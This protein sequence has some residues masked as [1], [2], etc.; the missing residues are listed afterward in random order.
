VRRDLVLICAAA[1]LRSLG[2]G[3]LGVVL[4]AYLARAEYSALKIGA[5]IA[6]GLAGAALATLVVSLRGDALVSATV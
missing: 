5:V 1:L 2:I 6:A 4:G 3:W